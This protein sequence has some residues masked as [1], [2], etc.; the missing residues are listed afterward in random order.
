MR[1]ARRLSQLFFFFLFVFLFLQARFPY[2][3]W[4]PSDLFL[5]FSPLVAISTF[6]STWSLELKMS[7]ALVLLLIS[8]LFGRFFCGWLCPLG[9]LIDFSDKI[10][11][12]KKNSSSLGKLRSLKFTLLIALLITAL[13]SVPLVWLFDPIVI[14]FRAFTVVF[15]PVFAYVLFGF[16]NAAFQVGVFEDQ[17]YSL[18]DFAQKT[19][20]PIDQPPLVHALPILFLFLAL[21]ILGFFGRR[22]W[23]RSLCPL[24]A[25]FGVFSRFRVFTRIV[26]ESCTSCGLCAKHCRMQAIASD[27]TT[28]NPVECIE[29]G[30]C[31]AECP[32][33]SISYR[34]R[35]PKAKPQSSFDLSRRRFIAASIAGLSSVAVVKLAQAKSTNSGTVIRPPGSIDENMFFEKCIRCQACTRICASTGGC[36]QPSL[37]EAGVDGMWSPIVMPNLGYCEYNCTLCGEIC[38]TGAIQKIPLDKKQRLKIGSAFFDKQA[39]IPWRDN[40]DCLVCEEH[41][42]VPD[43]AIKFDEKSVQLD[44]DETRVVKFPFVIQELCI[45]C[46]ICEAKCPVANKP[47]IY[48]TAEN[49]QRIKIT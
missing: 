5:H 17:V 31:V 41:C 11:F 43:K 16:F 14:L 40:T 12:R 9:T 34:F 20:L 10:F 48:V 13:F 29:C 45:G 4:L 47:G 42:P 49:N 26:D 6:L 39:C 38:P 1:L 22:F 27:F 24:G 30:Q 3:V 19:V 15:Y 33:H 28:T 25:L 23:C 35:L 46:G 8:L 44:T 18:Y 32:A 36:L 37:W 21:F 2:N 7:I